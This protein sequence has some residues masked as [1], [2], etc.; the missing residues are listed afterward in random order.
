[1]IK[2]I[3]FFFLIIKMSD[4]ATPSYRKSKKEKRL[5]RRYRVYKKGGKY[6]GMN[7]REK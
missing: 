6:R 2:F 5:K 7:I 3:N 1:M 4:Y